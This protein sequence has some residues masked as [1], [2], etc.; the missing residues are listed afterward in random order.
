MTRSS[1]V[2]GMLRPISTWFRKARVKSCPATCASVIPR[3][4]RSRRMR[5][6]RVSSPSVPEVL[7]SLLWISTPR[8]AGSPGLC[9]DYPQPVRTAPQLRHN[10][11]PPELQV[12]SWIEAPGQR[13]EVPEAVGRHH[14]GVLDPNP[15]KARLVQPRFHGHHVSGQQ[16][17]VEVAQLGPLVDLE[18]DAVAGRVDH[19]RG[20]GVALEA[21]RRRA[22]APLD[23][24][25]A[26]RAVDVA[27]VGA[28][29]QQAG[30]GVQ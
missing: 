21:L 18:A 14:A 15:A 23:E 1:R 2:E 30:G 24:S 3:S 5:C 28:L 19:S 22:E 10:P 26:H 8:I 16:R 11:P 7:A 17:V 6:P 13:R 9:T 25:P 27:A 12:V 29:A 20:V 4:C